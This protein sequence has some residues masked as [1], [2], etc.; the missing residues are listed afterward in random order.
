MHTRHE[1]VGPPVL[2]IAHRAPATP[3]ECEQLVSLGATFDDEL[4]RYTALLPDGS[5]LHGLAA[6]LRLLAADLA[7]LREPTPFD[8]PTGNREWTASDGP[9]RSDEPT[10][11]NEPTASE[12]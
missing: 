1:E 8:Q 5:G 3:G 4:A 2:A 7:T 10:P 9:S 11:S 12:P 6:Q